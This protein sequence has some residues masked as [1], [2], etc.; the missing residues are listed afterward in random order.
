MIVRCPSRSCAIG[1][2]F[3]SAR[4]QNADSDAAAAGRAPVARGSTRAPRHGMSQG[5][6]HFL[7]AGE[8]RGR[9]QDETTRPTQ[10]A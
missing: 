10:K 5:R 8:A 1:Q 9:W 7:A 3:A 2:A 4:C 6:A